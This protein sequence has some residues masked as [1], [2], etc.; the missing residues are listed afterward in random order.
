VTQTVQQE[1][2]E[3]EPPLAAAKPVRTL[4]TAYFDR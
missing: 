1:I 2:G 3:E 4:L